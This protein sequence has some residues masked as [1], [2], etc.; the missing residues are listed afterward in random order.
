MR[1][2]V[3]LFIFVAS[4]AGS[5]PA[6]AGPSIESVSPGVG[7]RGTEFTLELVG[8]NFTDPAEVVLYQ[9]GLTCMGVK[10]AKENGLSVRLKADATC[11][12]GQ[13]PFR[14]RTGQGLSELKILRV[15]PFRVMP[16]I[17]PNESPKQAMPVMQNVTV[18]GRLESGD[19]DCFEIT[20]HKG[21]R[22][23]AEV[24]AVRLGEHLVD[25]VLNV[26]G[27]DHK[28]LAK[29]DDT[30]LFRQDPFL[31][32][33][34]PV[35]GKYVVQIQEAAL[36]GDENSRY[37][38]HIGAFPR[39]AF[40]F[41]PGGPAGQTVA[42]RFHRD[43]LGIIEQQI[44]L[45]A[46]AGSD[47]G[48]FPELA[49]IACPTAI[50]FRVSPFGNQLEA[51]PND[52]FAA[53][54]G[55]PVDLPVAFNGV[56]EKTGD[57]DRF[58]FRMTQGQV[59]QFEAYADRLGS[60]ADTVISILDNAGELLVR[61]DDD[62][63]HDSR[64]VYQATRT[65]EYQLL[66]TD[67]RGAGGANFLYRVEATAP[68][69]RLTAFLPRPNRDSQERQ[70]IVVPRGNRAMALL[71]VRRDG[72]NSSVRL[73][74]AGLPAGTVGSVAN[75]PNDQFLTP[76]VFEAATDAPLGGSL[77]QVQVTG[78]AQ[79]SA[80]SGT[81]QQVV[82]LVHGSADTLYQS[83]TVDR[84]AVAVVEAAP[85]RMRL[86]EPK[87]SLAQ[88]GTLGLIVHIERAPEF[89]GA[90]DVT[91]PLLPPGV[92]GPAKMTIPGDQT[93]G[94]YLM[95]AFPKASV[96]SWPLC[97]EG[98]PAV[99]ASRDAAMNAAPGTPNSVQGVAR[100]R[101]GSRRKATNDFVVSSQLVTLNI[102]KSPVSGLIGRVASEQGGTLK[103]VCSVER[104]AAL[105]DSLVA[106]MEGL[107]NRVIASPITISANDQRVEFSIQLEPTAPVGTFSSLVCRL[108]G[109]V[110]GQQVSYCIGRGGILKIEPA[111]A[112]VTDS[113][114]R[115][116]SP[117]EILR[118]AREKAQAG[119]KASQ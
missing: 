43:A 84:L 59:S 73:E 66:V 102:S 103:L 47:F 24:E 37:A 36:E 72:V 60:Q 23:A 41:P 1:I 116:L 33:V 80:V 104:N 113:T 83:A 48:L 96:R 38:L 101:R 112:L 100:P 99:A 91:F 69:P 21:E 49:G 62:G 65:G 76:V 119:V 18:T 19:S 107:P 93:S 92:D 17:E 2:L 35:D 28:L 52:D 77:A 30:P 117:L 95:H 81:F 29:A 42:I 12:L 15:T 55:P 32:V 79:G 111:G 75:V 82:D 53:V 105:P 98:R 90:V 94:V 31:T 16:E 110:E 6:F 10:R 68:Q 61:N 20:L 86:E 56:L 88:D 109:I 118:Q 57:I 71:A 7:Q 64:L 63:S 14:L 11:P 58:W 106:T 67:K 87:A 54:S 8:A 114:G 22:L 51:E 40:A 74:T 5:I 45:P 27:P 115:P 85:F 39:P 3:K 70:T 97:A 46:S 78:E 4:L 25:T 9:P 44:I 108:T 89:D 26:F 13:H 50:P 34:A